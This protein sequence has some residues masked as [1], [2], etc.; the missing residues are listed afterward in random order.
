MA[1]FSEREPQ[2]HLL[3]P[4]DEALGP[5]ASS[6]GRQPGA[7]ESYWLELNLYE[8]QRGIGPT[9]KEA[10][11]YCGACQ[12]SVAYAEV[13]PGPVP[14]WPYCPVHKDKALIVCA[15]SLG[16]QDRRDLTDVYPAELAMSTEPGSG[17][18]EVSSD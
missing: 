8:F 1:M 3:F 6:R 11:F 15:T 9:G 4:G 14:D 7:D 16:L 5:S 12:S 18:E 13:V 10:M 17:L 2:Q